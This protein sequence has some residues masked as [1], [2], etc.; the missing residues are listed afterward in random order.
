MWIAG[1]ALSLTAAGLLAHRLYTERKKAAGAAAATAAGAAAAAPGA[2]AAPAAATGAPTSD[3]D[4][5]S[6]RD[7][8]SDSDSDSDKAE[9][10]S[11][12]W[13]TRAWNHWSAAQER[14]RAWQSEFGA[15]SRDFSEELREFAEPQARQ[16]RQKAR[17]RGA[18]GFGSRGRFARPYY[19]RQPTKLTKPT[20]P[21]PDPDEGG[22]ASD[23]MRTVSSTMGTQPRR[24]LQRRSLA[25]YV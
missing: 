5:D 10:S 9:A 18:G 11:S 21:Q 7:S 24:E 6:D 13:L 8:D 20:R 14:L 25:S 1:G 2:A 22:A 16:E 4:R 23:T 17:E 19:D 3:S 15:D 12:W